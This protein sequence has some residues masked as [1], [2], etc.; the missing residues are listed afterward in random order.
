MMGH[1]LICTRSSSPHRFPHN[2]IRRKIMYIMVPNFAVQFC[3]QPT[4][5]LSNVTLTSEHSHYCRLLFERC[6]LFC[7]SNPTPCFPP[8]GITSF[9]S[10]VLSR[11]DVAREGGEGFVIALSQSSDLKFRTKVGELS[12]CSVLCGRFSGVLTEQPCPEKEMH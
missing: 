8:N 4:D 5:I 11:L 10:S 1:D 3:E 12:T 2:K 7:M 9:P 6:P